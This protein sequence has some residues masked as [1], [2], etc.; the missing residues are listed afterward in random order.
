[1]IFVSIAGASGYTGGELLRLFLGHPEVQVAQVSSE[2]LAGKLVTNAHPNLRKH[3]KLKFS[4]LDQL[5]P[6]D[7]LFLCLPHGQSMDRI[8]AFRAL[9]P[10]LIDLSGDF[11]LNN[12]A[13]YDRWYGRT[14]PRPDVLSEFVYGLPEVHREKIREASYVTGAG[15]NATATILGLLPLYRAG[16]VRDAVVEVKAGSSE[17]GNMA[18]E[19]S[20]HPE[21]SGA[22][23]SYKPTGHRHVA[24]MLQVLGPSNIHFSATSIEMVRGILA[25]CHVFL[26]EDLDEKAIWKLYREAYSDEPFIRIVKERTGI[27]RYPEPKLLAGTNFCD[28]GFERDP[29]SDRLVVLSAIDNLMKGASGQAVQAFNLMHGLDEMTGLEFS[30][31]HP[32]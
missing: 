9:A 24:E 21:R 3:S 30:G 14:H 23:R 6:C 25:T 17:G 7:V 28:I 26:T 15:C 13:D 32:I 11:R 27:H 29:H 19:G 18:N 1:M 5:E 22:V 16:V 2:R 12:P 4:S 8:D 10:K 20:H 31:L